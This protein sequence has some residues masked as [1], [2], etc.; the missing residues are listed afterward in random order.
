[1]RHEPT[2]TIRTTRRP[3]S[4]APQRRST[5]VLAAVVAFALLAGP[6]FADEPDVERIA[7]A[8]RIA[9]AVAASEA[10]G[11]NARTAV[12]A[13]RDLFPDALGAPAVAA[14]YDAPLLLTA[15]DTLPEATLEEFERL[16][17]QRVIVLGGVAAVSAEVEDDLARSGYDIER[18]AGVDRFQTAALI[19]ALVG[20]GEGDG[21][22]LVAVGQTDDGGIPWPDAVAGASLAATDARP[23]TVLTQP[24]SLPTVT[25]AALQL[26]QPERVRLLGGE[27]AIGRVVSTRI[28][29]AGFEVSRL[30]GDDRYATA[31]AVADEALEGLPEEGLRPIVVSGRSLAD[32]VVGATLAARTGQPLLYTHTDRLTEVAATFLTAHQDRFEGATVV[33]G[34]SSVAEDVEEEIVAALEADPPSDPPPGEDPPGNGVPPGWQPRDGWQL[35]EDLAMCESSYGADEPNWQLVHTVRD[36]QGNPVTYYGGLQFDLPSWRGA[37]GS[38]LPSE[39]SR[40]EQIY[41]GEIWQG[42]HPRGWGAWPYCADRLELLVT[43]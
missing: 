16:G 23:P 43:R 11:N 32:A 2:A 31:V 27:S 38:G 39:A 8:D 10:A 34:T 15:T 12:L 13:N 17:V 21:E 18:R 19:A 36:S 26:L 24:G 7:G 33:G 4:R 9:T 3:R 42:I 20:L 35:W 37:G 22:M 25:L 28:D 14:R 30:S 40:V 41:R 5:A 6:A 29:A 1:M